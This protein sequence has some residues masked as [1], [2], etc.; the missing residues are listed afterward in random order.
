MLLFFAKALHTVK[1]WGAVMKLYF[2]SIPFFVF[3]ISSCAQEGFYNSQQKNLKQ[4]CE[5]LSSPQYEACLRELDNTSYDEY[6]RERERLLEE[7]VLEEKLL[8]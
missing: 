2:I 8:D 5:K 4:E 7:E 1:L 3:L 6:R